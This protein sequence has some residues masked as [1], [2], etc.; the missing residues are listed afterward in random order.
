VHDYI[1]NF[2]YFPHVLLRA[3]NRWF[4]TRSSS[5]AVTSWEYL[6]KKKKCLEGV[7]VAPDNNVGPEA[8]DLHGR[9][10]AAV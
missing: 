8:D 3:I 4:A 6:K 7:E 9:V 1:S 2:D 10:E 5:F